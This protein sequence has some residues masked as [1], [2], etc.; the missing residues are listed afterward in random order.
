MSKWHNVEMTYQEFVEVC[1]SW[2]QR[3]DLDSLFE[4]RMKIRGYRKRVHKDG[5]V[6]IQSIFGFNEFVERKLNKMLKTG[7]IVSHQR[8]VIYKFKNGSD[9]M[10]FKLMI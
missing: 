9:A 3:W 1:E 10:A 2:D 4:G 8:Y 6:S 5:S 7:E